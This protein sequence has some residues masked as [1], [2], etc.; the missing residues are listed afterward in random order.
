MFKASIAYVKILRASLAYVKKFF[1]RKKYQS[2]IF[3]WKISFKYLIYKIII[4]M[5]L[6]G[7]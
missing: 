6:L 3:V 4:K 1:S 7:F 5:R 2:L